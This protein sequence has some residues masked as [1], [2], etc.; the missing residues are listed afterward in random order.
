MAKSIYDWFQL[1][2]NRDFLKRLKERGVKYFVEKRGGKLLNKKFV[3]TGTLEEMSRDIAK[4]KIIALGG[5]VS[6][7]ISKN[8][9]YLIVG[10]NPGSKY[11][12]AKSLGVHIL[13]EKEFLKMIN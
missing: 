9:D 3:I 13:K 2:E 10:E 6:D 8:I 1:K 7:A 12:K 11:E 4:E 5:E